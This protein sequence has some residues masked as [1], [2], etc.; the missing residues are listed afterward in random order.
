MKTKIKLIL[1]DGS[2]VFLR[3]IIIE[4]VLCDYSYHWQSADGALIIRWD[5]SPHFPDISSTYPHHKHIE[6]EASVHPSY[7]Q[8]LF[9][10]LTFIRNNISKSL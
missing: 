5:N 4:K 8:N 3:E 1:I 6:T 9:Q 7:E 10:V 2:V